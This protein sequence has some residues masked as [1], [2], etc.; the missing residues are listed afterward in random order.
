MT[1]NLLELLLDS[2]RT[3]RHL[4]VEDVFLSLS[5]LR[6]GSYDSRL[7]ALH[8]GSY[9][10][11]PLV[12]LVV[13]DSGTRRLCLQ[14][15]NVTMKIFLLAVF[16]IV[17]L[18]AE[19]FRMVDLVGAQ[20]F[21]C[22]GE[23]EYRPYETR[24]Y[25]AEDTYEDIPLNRILEMEVSCTSEDILFTVKK[26]QNLLGPG[27]YTTVVGGRE[28]SLG[29]GEYSTRLVANHTGTSRSAVQNYPMDIRFSGDGSNLDVHGCGGPRIHYEDVDKC[30][31]V[32][33]TSSLYWRN[34]YTEDVS[35]NFSVPRSVL[36]KVLEERQNVSDRH[37]AGLSTEAEYDELHIQY[38]QVAH[39][40]IFRIEKG[41]S[42]ERLPRGM[43]RYGGGYPGRW[44]MFGVAEAWDG[45]VLTPDH[46][47]SHGT[48]WGVIPIALHRELNR[49]QDYWKMCSGI[50]PSKAK[51]TSDLDAT[52]A[53]A[54]NSIKMMRDLSDVWEDYKEHTLE[55][56]IKIP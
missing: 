1:A 25:T 56:F 9:G 32:Q 5:G 10:V 15:G 43:S 4:E 8:G 51:P 2:A 49:L 53:A 33:T 27:P 21:R 13:L 18:Q 37:D 28:M 16:A 41:R 12:R 50:A 38:W 40:S 20:K 30:E 35:V 19:T 29:I 52:A 45:F 42:R 22:S 34:L 48:S 17:G 3:A 44:I 55:D 7:S 14:K 26:N 36:W 24:M 6:I 46:R 47:S 39:P 31:T 23:H 54:K 11:S